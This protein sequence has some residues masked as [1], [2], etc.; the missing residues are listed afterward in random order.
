MRYLLIP[1]ILANEIYFNLLYYMNAL[2]MD[3]GKD[4]NIFN[5]IHQFMF[6]P[7]IIVNPIYVYEAHTNEVYSPK[8]NAWFN[9]WK[10]EFYDGEEKKVK[11]PYDHIP[12]YIRAGSI[13]PYGPWI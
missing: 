3:F 11:D 8:N 1:Y 6:I 13:I 9:F 5:I 2:V 7:A 4:K 12:I 10:N